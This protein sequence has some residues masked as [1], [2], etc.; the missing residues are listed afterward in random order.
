MKTLAFAVLLGAVGCQ[1]PEGTVVGGDVV[2]VPGNQV[3]ARR[4][5]VTI[6]DG[7]NGAHV[8]FMN[9]DGVAL[10]RGNDDATT[11]TSWITNASVT[12]K[13]FNDTP[14]GMG[15]AATIN[16]IAG[17]MK[18]YY[19]PFNAQIVTTR[20]A[21]G[22]YMMCLVGGN[23]GVIGVGGGAAGIAPLDCDNQ[24]ES[25]VV[26]AFSE[27]LTPQ[28]TGST[29]ESLKA[30]A[31]TCAQETAHGYGLGHTTNQADVMYPQLTPSVTGFGG[32]SQL[33]NDGSG[34]CSS[35]STT[36][37]SA[38]MLKMVIGASNGMTT[39]GP[40]PTVQWVT[41]TDGA[42]VPL[43]F[44][45]VI[46]ASETGGTISKVDITS[47]GQTVASLTAPPFKKTVT[48]PGDGTYQL[49]AV[50]YDSAGNLQS[51]S[52]NF[53]AQ[54]G[55]PPQ[56]TEC[57]TAAECNSGEDCTGGMC[58]TST[59]P[60]CA[61]P[62]PAGQTCQADGTCKASGGGGSD[63]GTGG[64]APGEI[65]ANCADGSECHSGLC[66]SLGSQHF[67]TATCDPANTS[68]C[69]S[70]NSCVAAGADHIC[71]PNNAGG[72]TGVGCSA[73]P[74]RAP[75][76]ETILALCML[77]GLGLVVALHRAVRRG[78]GAGSLQLRRRLRD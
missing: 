27:V 2:L 51:A 62:C 29:T 78:R 30:I 70:G 28:N 4:E 37:D 77:F 32:P 69:P 19:A 36:Q 55:A 39:T 61:Q 5:A 35:P 44:D 6:G 33:Q 14:Y 64:P 75:A 71:Q 54:A 26:Y 22:R 18:M 45:I 76:S 42:T 72:G 56:T 23:P 7:P 58:V 12:Y 13:A 50:A 67:C 31:A 16:A 38:G 1:A 60:T 74:G 24:E 68:S 10:N 65:G 25:N 49:T 46:A 41:P 52:I 15:R 63:G 47:G 53:T 11:N 34:Q 8:I 9:F 57:L 3:G 17:Y 20:P 66:A 21:S 73:I 59:G 43:T 40:T 48:A